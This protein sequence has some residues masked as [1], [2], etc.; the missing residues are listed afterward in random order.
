MFFENTPFYDIELLKAELG[1]ILTAALEVRKFS[2]WLPEE[3][4]TRFA[5][6]SFAQGT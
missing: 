6:Q 5:G 4:Y 3:T 2:P 1:R